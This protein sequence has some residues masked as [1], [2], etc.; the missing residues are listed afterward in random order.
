MD[1]NGKMMIS[2]AGQKGESMREEQDESKAE[3][4]GCIPGDCGESS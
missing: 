3:A 2:V 1:T 4:D